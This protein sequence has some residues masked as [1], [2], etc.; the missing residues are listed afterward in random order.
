M[1]GKVPTYWFADFW[2]I[3]NSDIYKSLS[4]CSVFVLFNKALSVEQK[5]PATFSNRTVAPCYKL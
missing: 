1:R 2:D 3:Y 4:I 5:N